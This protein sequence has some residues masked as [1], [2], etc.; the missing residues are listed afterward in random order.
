MRPL[1]PDFGRSLRLWRGVLL[2]IACAI[3]MLLF[4]D[5]SRPPDRSES[6]RFLVAIVLGMGGIVLYFFDLRRT[7]KAD[8]K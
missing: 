8:Q 3:Y 1:L 6:W 5:F 2:T 7:R 4:F